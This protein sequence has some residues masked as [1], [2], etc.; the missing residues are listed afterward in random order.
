MSHISRSAIGFLMCCFAS[1]ALC[2]PLEPLFS[3]T[4]R[5]QAPLLETLKEIVSIES[6]S[7]D[8]AGIAQLADVVARRLKALGAEVELVAPRNVYKMEDTPDSIGQM[9]RATFIGTGKAK[10]LLIAHM[11]IIQRALWRSNRFASKAIAPMDL[12]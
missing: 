4:T 8:A 9:V 12:E 6:G 1:S 11:D 5:E 3:L 7:R 10:I 2:A